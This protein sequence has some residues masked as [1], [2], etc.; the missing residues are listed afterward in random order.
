[1]AG[2]E[3]R[4]PELAVIIVNRNG[5]IFLPRC[6]RSLRECGRGRDWEI[7]VADNASDDGSA[8]LMADSFPEVKLLPTGGNLGFAKA[9]NMALGETRSPFILFLNPDT[10]VFEGAVECLL[11]VLRRNPETGAC[12]PRLIL[13][14]HTNQVSFGGTVSFFRELFQKAVLNPYYKKRLEALRR[15]REVGWVS[16]ACLLARREAVDQAGG[17][18]E[19]FFLYF[20]DIDLCRRMALRGWRILFVPA[21]RVFHEGGAATRRFAPSRYE[22]RK[23]QLLFYRKHNGPAAQRLLRAY[24][25]MN[26]FFLG[27]R[28]RRKGEGPESRA[29]FKSLLDK[30]EA[31]S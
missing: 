29:S 27:L 21:A 10:A 8:E 2:A 28:A 30:P 3:G 5:R 24:L 22:Y 1:M 16:G 18:D 12:G 4:V 19:D 7:I 17:F 9:N 20:E 26:F 25:R 15:P 14:D 6:L 31:K 11:E 13:G 23:S